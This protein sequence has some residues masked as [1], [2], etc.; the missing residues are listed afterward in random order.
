MASRRLSP[1]DAAWLY[2]EWEKNNQTVSAVC[3]TD[4]LVDPE[5]F[6]EIVQERMVDPFPTF[7]RRL[8]KSRNP[9][10]LPHWEDDPDFDINNHLEVI[11]LAPPGDKTQLRELISQQR[12]PMLDRSRP[13]WKLYQFQG[14]NGDATAFHVRIQH[15]I[16][17][18]WAL[19]RVVLSLAD[20]ADDLEKPQPLAKKRVRKR[21]V[22]ARAAAPAR[23]AVSG[24][25]GAA[26]KATAAVKG[27]EPLAASLALDLDPKRFVEFGTSVAEQVTTGWSDLG[28]RVDQA[29]AAVD[30]AT[31]SAKDAADY[32]TS[33]FPGSTVLHG[34]V[35]GEKKVDWIEPIPLQPIKDA[36]RAAGATINDAILGVLTNTLRKYLAEHDSLT[37]DDLYTAV[38]VSLRRPDTPLP[39]ELGNRFGVVPVL[40]PVGIEDPREQM[41]EVKRRLDEIKSSQMPVVS[42]GLISVM[43]L[44]TPDVERMVHK[45]HQYQSIG[46]TTNVPGPRQ[47]ITVAG[48]R[49]L[50]MW[51][52]GGLSGNQNL[53]FG[54]FTLAGKLNFSVHTDAGITPDP[55]RILSLFLESVDDLLEATAAQ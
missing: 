53:S 40:L 47:E 10:Y 42:F 37:V 21:D 6:R 26:E 7:R 14:Y 24:V 32:L 34:K 17:D 36:G 25:A 4:R 19:V 55:D 38:P 11:E 33:E 52:M 48:A 2:S 3:W 31:T 8:R 44:T 16:A 5:Q 1:A 46:V 20:A 28:R 54:I 43:A 27:E 35:T 39:R 45:V 29:R 22:L 13:L 49:V 50:G 30:T 18:G 12:G 23:D 9:V 41:L 51:G 15:S